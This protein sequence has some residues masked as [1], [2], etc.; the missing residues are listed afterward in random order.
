MKCN[1]VCTKGRRL[2]SSSAHGRHSGKGE[3]D[4]GG[5]SGYFEKNRT[6][7]TPTELYSSLYCITRS[8]IH[9]D[10]STVRNIPRFYTNN[11]HPLNV[12]LQIKLQKFNAAK[13]VHNSFSLVTYCI[14]TGYRNLENSTLAISL[15]NT[16]IQYP[17]RL[18]N[19]LL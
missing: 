7:M 3:A 8:V 15:L 18:V 14:L 5:S 12:R 11:M 19:E 16:D 9:N 17:D 2:K 6:V 10:Y 1:V 4:L 13:I